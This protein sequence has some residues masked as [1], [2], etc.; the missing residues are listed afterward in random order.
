MLNQR[1]Y[2]IVY[3]RYKTMYVVWAAACCRVC[4][5]ETVEWQKILLLHSVQW[6]MCLELGAACFGIS[7][8]LRKNVC[9][10]IGI[11]IIL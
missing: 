9:V 5:G 1:L 7:E 2:I 8:F 3:L 4:I 10:G 6:L 11:A